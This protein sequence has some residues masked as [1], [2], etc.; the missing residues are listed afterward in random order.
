MSLVLLLVQG[1]PINF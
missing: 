1:H